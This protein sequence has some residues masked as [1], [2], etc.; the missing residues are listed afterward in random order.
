[1]SSGAQEAQQ[2]QQAQG[3]RGALGVIA[4]TGFY[5]LDDL[6]DPE[7]VTVDTAFGPTRARIGTVHDRRTVFISRHGYD[8]SVPPHM[9]NYRANI[10]AMVD[11]GVSEILAINVVGGVGTDS[12]DLVIVDDFI[13]FTKARPVTFYDG[14]TPEGHRKRFACS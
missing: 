3:T 11:L 10:Q 5:A 1:M 8:H 4:G 6:R 7:D 9:V 14:S 2:A 13:D 12:G